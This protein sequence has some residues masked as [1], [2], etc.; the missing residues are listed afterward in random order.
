MNKYS[1]NSWFNSQNLKMGMCD[2]CGFFS[3]DFAVTKNIAKM[4]WNEAL[5]E[6]R[7][8]VDTQRDN[9]DAHDAYAFMHK[10]LEKL[11]AK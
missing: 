11:H 8:Q 9:G 1:F 6:V 7:K 10:V 3:Y 4:A 2:V 5:E